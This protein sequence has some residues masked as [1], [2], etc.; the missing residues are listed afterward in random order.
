MTAPDTYYL[1][2]AQAVV[3]NLQTFDLWFPKIG[4][5]AVAAWAAHFEA[6]GLSAEDLVAGVD[7]AR[8]QHIKVAQARAEARSEPVEQFRPTPDMIVSHAHAA[9]RDVLASLPKERVTEMEMANHILQE[10][11]FTP[12]KAHRLSR[13]IA[14][15]VALKRPA[16]H[17]LTAAELEEFKGRVA[18]AKQAAISHVDRRREIASTIKL[19]NL[20]GIESKQGRA[21]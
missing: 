20:F 8:A 13:D 4:A 16:Q 11:G 1:D 3:D 17:N 6:S 12:Q 15:A 19:A 10:M 7:H 18:A 2:A 5:A 14:L 9:R 21:S